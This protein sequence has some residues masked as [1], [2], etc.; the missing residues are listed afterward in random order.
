MKK[1]ESIWAELSA[2]AQEVAQESTELSEEVKVELAAADDLKD[3]S[4]NAKQ[5]INAFNKTT[6]QVVSGAKELTKVGGRVS[7]SVFELSK[8]MQKV[9]ASAKELGVDTKSVDGYAEAKRIV[10][11]AGVYDEVRS[12]VQRIISDLNEFRNG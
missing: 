2:K 4:Q 12:I 11:E 5:L 9:E 10:S 1:V 7:S 8:V 3:A 6:S